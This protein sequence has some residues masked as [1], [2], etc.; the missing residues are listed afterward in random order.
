ME[1]IRLTSSSIYATLA[2]VDDSSYI[3]IGSEIRSQKAPDQTPVFLSSELIYLNCL[4]TDFFQHIHLSAVNYDDYLGLITGSEK[5]QQ[6]N[7]W[8]I[9]K[10]QDFFF[11]QV[12]F[13]FDRFYIIQSNQQQ[14]L[15]PRI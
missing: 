2:N 11:L 7:M 5:N 15:H 13:S 12:M 4:A 1:E 6:Q 14:V 10:G 8:Q 3:Y 9:Q